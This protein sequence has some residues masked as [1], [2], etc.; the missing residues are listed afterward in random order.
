MWRTVLLVTA[1]A[2]VL[3]VTACGT[4]PRKVVPDVTGEPL[5][6]AEDTLDAVGLRYRTAGGGF[7]GIIVRS[8][9]VVC[10]Q[11][12]APHR[13]SSTVLLT[14]ARACTVPDVVGQSLDDAEDELDDRGI[15]V[16]EISLDGEP[17]ILESRWT[18]CRES[19]AAGPP[20][21]AGEPVELYVSHDCTWA[22]D[23]T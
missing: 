22:G 19:P 9:W 10:K 2:L 18:V 14:V 4:A 8:N 6:V 20:V 1:T 17:I 5:N 11:S 13:V 12:P 3:A 21:H 23:T 15:D 7:F 16:R